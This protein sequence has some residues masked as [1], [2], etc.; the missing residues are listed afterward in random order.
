MAS[1]RV[2]VDRDLGVRIYDQTT[3]TP[4]Y[5]LIQFRGDFSG[6]LGRPRP[7]EELMISNGK[8][9]TTVMHYRVL[10]DRKTFEPLE[11]TLGGK[12]YDDNT[13]LG[14]IDFLSNPFD[15]ATWSALVTNLTGVTTMGA[16]VNADGTSV[17]HP[18]PIDAHRLASQVNVEILWDTDNTN[19][20]GVKYA[21]VFFEADA[22][23]ISTSNEGESEWEATGTIRGAITLLTAHTLGVAVT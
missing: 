18:T 19:D 3:G 17:T 10:T 12:L 5:Q 23:N 11:F 4:K 1:D 20:W 14:I 15:E 8:A 21:G 16:T 2:L 9:E 13:T 22:T 6:P 7:E